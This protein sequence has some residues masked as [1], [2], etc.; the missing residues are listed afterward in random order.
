MARTSTASITSVGNLTGPQRDFISREGPDPKN[1]DAV[2]IFTRRFREE[3]QVK[4]TPDKMQT[5]LTNFQRKERRAGNGMSAA[6]PSP[7]FVRAGA[8]SGAIAS[9]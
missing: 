1:M 3:F 4:I 9:R 7:P 6:S 8:Y 2:R 5:I